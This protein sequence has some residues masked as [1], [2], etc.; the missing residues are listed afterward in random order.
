MFHPEHAIFR[1]SWEAG[2]NVSSIGR[3]RCAL[4]VAVAAASVGVAAQ[5]QLV[6]P[7]PDSPP[8]YTYSY[9]TYT[10]LGWHDVVVTEHRGISGW[11]I[12]YTWHTEDD[13][14]GSAASPPD[15]YPRLSLC[16]QSSWA[17]LC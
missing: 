9:N 11:S 8:F 15:A 7:L 6:L 12:N 4:V 10:E 5:D 3:L 2:E 14:F 1:V 16:W 13:F 17:S